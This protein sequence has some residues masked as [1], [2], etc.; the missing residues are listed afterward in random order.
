MKTGLPLNLDVKTENYIKDFVIGNRLK[1][2][3]LHFIKGDLHQA[4][5]N[6]GKYFRYRNVLSVYGGS[7]WIQTN[8][9]ESKAGCSFDLFEGSRVKNWELWF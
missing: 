7:K 6:E 4:S 8:F 5:I 3:N 2:E 1:F 9:G